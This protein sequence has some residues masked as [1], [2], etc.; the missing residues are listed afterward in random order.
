VKLTL[1]TY[2]LIPVGNPQTSEHALAE[3]RELAAQSKAELEKA[4][5]E[6]KSLQLTLQKERAVRE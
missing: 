5:Q 3:V 1:L 4:K 2:V 6:L